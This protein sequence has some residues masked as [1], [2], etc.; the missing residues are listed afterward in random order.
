MDARRLFGNSGERVAKEYLQK[1]GWHILQEQY[2]TRFGE[3]DLIA[4]DKDEYVFVEVKTRRSAENGYPEETITANKLRHI[5]ASAEEYLSV[6]HVSDAPFRIDVIAIMITSSV[7]DIHH[8]IA[9]DMQG[10]S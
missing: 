2:R 5:A 10:S 6:H 9:V 8:L 3:I 4:K 1:K 7:P